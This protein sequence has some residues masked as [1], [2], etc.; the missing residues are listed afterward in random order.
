MILLF[1]LSCSHKKVPFFFIEE[2]IPDGLHFTYAEEPSAIPAL[3]G[4]TARWGP[5]FYKNSLEEACLRSNHR[6]FYQKDWGPKLE[7]CFASSPSVDSLLRKAIYQLQEQPK[8]R[9]RSQGEL[10]FRGKKVYLSWVS[11]NGVAKRLHEEGVEDFLL[12]SNVFLDPLA[13]KNIVVTK[14]NLWRTGFAAAYFS[15]FQTRE[16][17][18]FIFTSVNLQTPIN[19]YHHLKIEFS[20]DEE[21]TNNFKHIFSQ[22]RQSNQDKREQC[23]SML[24]EISEVYAGG[25]TLTEKYIEL[26]NPHPHTLCF[27]G[28]RVQL[29]GIN[30]KPEFSLDYLLPGQTLLLLEEK[31]K[32]Q[33]IELIGFPWSELLPGRQF[34]LKVQDLLVDYRIPKEHSFHSDGENFS[35]KNKEFSPCTAY[36][37]IYPLNSFCG[38][39]GLELRKESAVTICQVK[40]FS[41]NEINAYG[42]Q[43]QDKVSYH[44]K[45]LELKYTGEQTCDISHLYLHISGYSY[46]FTTTSRLVE[47]GTLLLMGR[48]KNLLPLPNLFI[49]N[50]I[51]LRYEQAI[52]LRGNGEEKEIYPG[53]EEGFYISPKD[54]KNRV[55][56]LSHIHGIWQH[57]SQIS[58]NLNPAI[59]TY[60]FMSPA[61]PNGEIDPLQTTYLNEV[62]WM[63]SFSQKV[64]YP[65]DE[66]IEIYASHPTSLLVSV[67]NITSIKQFLIPIAEAGLSVLTKKKLYCFPEVPFIANSD[68]SLPNSKS[69][70]TLYSS[71]KKKIWDSVVYDPKLSH[72]INDTKSSQRI[73]YAFSGY[74][75][76]WL[77]SSPAQTYRFCLTDTIASPGEENTFLPFLHRVE[78]ELE[79]TFVY[80][81]SKDFTPDKVVLQQKSCLQDDTSQLE[82]P[83]NFEGVSWPKFQLPIHTDQLGSS[84]LYTS[85]VNGGKSYFTH[86]SNLVIAAVLPNP[87]LAQN[88]WILLCN[89]GREIENMH[90]FRIQDEKTS[91]S[92]VSLAERGIVKET[93]LLQSDFFVGDEIL[94]QPQQCAYILDPDASSLSLPI[95]GQTPPL[96]LTVASSTTIGNGLSM[97][98]NLDL[99]KKIAGVAEEHVHTYGNSCEG[100]I[101]RIPLAKDEASWLRE[102]K[103]GDSITDYEVIKF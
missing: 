49:R 87:T 39:P 66:F 27:E 30:A 57:H 35:Y 32:L 8:D 6:F 41:L 33:G 16:S 58:R 72:G 48:G 79:N 31:S 62:S 60:N 68:F 102:D 103:W 69:T 7:L 1:L 78:T 21:N 43:E 67:Q 98:E 97:S 12:G 14:D 15:V 29:A 47:S 20:R 81:H 74:E 19:S 101:F 70:I 5:E 2:K 99:Y 54:S 94:L 93:V 25:N 76:Q 91:D 77:A 86:R 3:T 17:L 22:T 65:E 96:L 92:L 80:V 56:S 83:L 40:D 51:K 71:D 28:L 84:L 11:T 52:L 38:D 59:T 75:K 24:P 23:K 85:L 4:L 37:K 36:H 50:L 95:Y 53:L 90:N 64:S 61:A 100:S 89:R 63:G 88:E 42:I 46:P 10:Q 82:I 34:Q 9:V 26:Y 55:Y 45:F 18:F 73:S 13:K 44:E